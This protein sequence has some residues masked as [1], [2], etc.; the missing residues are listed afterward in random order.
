MEHFTEELQEQL[1]VSTVF[2]IG[3]IGVAESTVVTWIIMAILVGLSVYLG[4]DLK[5]RNPGKK[6]QLAEIIVS[7]FDNF[8]GELLGEHGKQYSTIISVILIYIGVSNL[9]GLFGLKPPTKDLNVTVGLSVISIFLIEI[10]GF[11]RKGAK[12]WIKH[13]SEPVAIVTPINILELVIRPLSLC[14]RLFGNVLGAFIIM[15]LIKM[16]VPVGVP[17]IFSLY[18]DIFDGLIQ[19]Y[20]F[21]FLTSLYIQDATE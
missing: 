9:I 13:F 17:A 2:S 4:S 20:V 18:F 19:A 3:G 15:E 14:M 8:T 5:V 12:G 6:Q 11:R 7:W 10:A 16:V 21:V 1:Q